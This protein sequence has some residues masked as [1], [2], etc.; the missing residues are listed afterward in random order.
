MLLKNEKHEK[1]EKHKKQ[2]EKS[3]N[4]NNESKQIKCENNASS[5]KQ[6]QPMPNTVSPLRHISRTYT[7]F[8][9]IQVH[10]TVIFVGLALYLETQTCAV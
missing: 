7:F 1:R 5:L 3:E 10:C 9:E 6:I 4:I 8:G 2:H